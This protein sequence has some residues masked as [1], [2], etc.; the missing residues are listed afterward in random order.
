LTCYNVAIVSSDPL[1]VAPP[2]T[3]VTDSLAAKFCK[4]FVVVVVCLFAEMGHHMGSAQF[5]ETLQH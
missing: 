5:P 3:K 2:G 1:G 4:H